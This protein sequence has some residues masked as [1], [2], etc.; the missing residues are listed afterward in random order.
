MKLTPFL[1]LMLFAA[2]AGCIAKALP[3]VA[4]AVPSRT[5]NYQLEVKPIL[6]RRCTVCHSC[7]NSPCQLK[8]DSYEGTD[9]GAT[10]KA[11]YN[12]SRLRSMDPTRPFRRCAEYP[13]MADK[14]VL[15]RHEKQ[16]V[17]AQIMIR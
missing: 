1:Y 13:G 17:P 8:L 4:V 7:Y 2:L 14:G 9:R 3:P 15:Q 12:A 11:I 10:K 16:R 6:D 5:I